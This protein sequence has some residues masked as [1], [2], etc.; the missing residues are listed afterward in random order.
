MKYSIKELAEL[1]GLTTRTLRYYDEINLLKPATV[2]ENGYRYYGS[3]ELELLQQIMF[4]R[5]RGFELKEIRDIINN[6]EYD[7]KE[8][9]EQHLQALEQEK[10]NIDSL[11]R[12]IKLTILTME[13]TC[14]MS[15]KERFEVFKN[16]LVKENEAKYGTE[17]REKYGDDTIDESN[18]KFLDMNEEKYNRFKSLEEEIKAKLEVAVNEGLEPTSEEGKELTVLHKEWLLMTWKTYSSEAHKGLSKMYVFD[19][20]FKSYYDENV[21]GCA[22]FLQ[23]AIEHWA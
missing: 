4:Y 10:I 11:I 14:S 6:P 15:D 21:E 22:D 19:E 16:Q 18:K 9:L 17:I 5:E 2:G 12:N 13:G 3:K 7:V 20:R 8:A 23:K 1:T